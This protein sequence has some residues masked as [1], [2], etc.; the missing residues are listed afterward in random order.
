MG[1]RY[2]GEAA[3]IIEV[4]LAMNREGPGALLGSGSD[5]AFQLAADR[6]FGPNRRLQQ[7][8]IE[9]ALSAFEDEL[10]ACRV[11]TIL[12]ELQRLNTGDQ[13]EIVLPLLKQRLRSLSVEF[14]GPV[15]QVLLTLDNTDPDAL[16]ALQRMTERTRSG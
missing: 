2:L 16:A 13:Q 1:N 11:P 4:C 5:L 8:L 15:A 3:N 10:V 9:V 7:R 6:S 14:V 12:E